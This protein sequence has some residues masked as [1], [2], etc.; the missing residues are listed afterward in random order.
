MKFVKSSDIFFCRAIQCISSEE[1]IFQLGGEMS[2][3]KFLQNYL[4]ITPTK[5][6]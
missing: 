3:S 2:R 1:I 6:F 5:H 4:L